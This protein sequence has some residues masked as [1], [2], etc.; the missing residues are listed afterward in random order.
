MI[1]QV[2]NVFDVSVTTGSQK[3]G[4]VLMVFKP[5]PNLAGNDCSKKMK[6]SRVHN[7]DNSTLTKRVKFSCK[8]EVDQKPLTVIR[9][10]D[11]QKTS[12]CVI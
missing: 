2:S 4:S 11:T 1:K 9:V 7:L 5:K 6:Q 10:P 3:V 12:I 8:A